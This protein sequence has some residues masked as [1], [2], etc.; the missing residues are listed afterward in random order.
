MILLGTLVF[1][2]L[3]PMILQQF[4]QHCCQLNQYADNQIWMAN[5]RELLLT[6]CEVGL[7][8]LYATREGRRV[9]SYIRDGYM[10]T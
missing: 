9:M 7:L 2:S 6:F 3:H 1:I 8:M 10:L 5:I 4:A